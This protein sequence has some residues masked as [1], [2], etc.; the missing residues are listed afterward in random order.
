M[1]K[2]VYRK[3]SCLIT[4][5][6]IVAN[7]GVKPQESQ[8]GLI[9]NGAVVYQEGKGI[10]WSGKD[11]ALPKEFKKIKSLDCKGLTA[12]PGL[13]DAHT[14]PVFAGDRSLEF[15]LRMQGAT[16]QEIATA[17]GGI[18]T[19][20]KHTR[21]AT[22]AELEKSL[23]KRIQTAASFGVRLMECKSGYGLDPATE[24]RSLE[25][26]KKVGASQKNVELIATC[27][28]AHA[29]PAEKKNNR[30]EYI[31]EVIEKIIPIVAKKKLASYVDVFC[32]A[33]YF[34]VEET[35]KISHAAQ[36]LGLSIRLHGEELAQTGIAEKAAEIGAHS[37]DHLLKISDAGISQ[38]ARAGTVGILLPGT[39]FYL[40]EK[41]AP[42]R[43]M[44]DAGMIVAMATDFNPGT[45]PTQNLPFIGSLGAISLGLTTAE[46]IAAI[47]WNAARSL[48]KEN[49]YGALLAGYKGKPAFVEGDHPSAMFY[50][51]APAAL[52]DPAS[53]TR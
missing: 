51:L 20:V 49:S 12:Y 19:S 10:L 14:H 48:R 28:A 22:K 33:G 13:V 9:A 37:V 1:K 21:A 8:L 47:T 53:F 35:I 26:I 18:V 50:R 41:P 36:K 44:I 30:E 23:L 7:Q 38:M 4:N 42:A 31:R 29:I 45:C 46:I 25:T 2:I 52:P 34:S 43:K 15:Q 24:L 32:D 27:L 11:S 5:E 40:R 16:Y 17:G 3:I 6:G 39:S